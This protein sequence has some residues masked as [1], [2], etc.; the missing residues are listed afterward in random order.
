MLMATVMVT[1]D[2]V[3]PKWLLPLSLALYA[4]VLATQFNLPSW[5]VQGEWFFNPL[6]WQLIFVLGFVLAK[7][8]GIGGFV[9]RNIVTIRWLSLPVV[10]FFL[11]VVWF[12][13]WHD[14]T[15]VPEPRLFFLAD[16]T[17][18]TPIRV[19]QFLALVAVMSVTFPYI[20]RL[21]PPIVSFCSLLGRN[22][23]YVF[24]MGSLLSLNGQIVRAIYRGSFVVDTILA[25]TG[26]AI[27][28]LTAWLPE[29]RESIRHR[30]Q[31]K[32]QPASS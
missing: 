23:L 32:Q 18:V 27:I 11:L 6:A 31:P 5:P 25:V 15:K 8:Q 12:D 17:F 4:V 10:I 26:I 22:S 9:R 19:F 29:W 2:H 30:P 28:A 3:A 14:P 24:C 16:K 20:R 7:P 13:W 21:I 1:I